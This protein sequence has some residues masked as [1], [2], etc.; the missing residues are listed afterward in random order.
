MRKVF[1]ILSTKIGV[2]VGPLARFRLIF[3]ALVVWWPRSKK[4]PF[5]EFCIA[6]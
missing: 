2:L 6:T 3:S 5:E 4:S 1:L